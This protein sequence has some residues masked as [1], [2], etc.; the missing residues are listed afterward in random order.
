AMGVQTIIVEEAGTDEQVG[1]RAEDRDGSSVAKDLRLA[2]AQVDA[3][4]EERLR[5]EQVV[6]LIDADIVAVVREKFVRKGD[7]REVLRDVRLD[8]Q[9]WIFPDEGLR[10]FHLRR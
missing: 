10:G 7:L 8:V 9:V 4:A 6:L 1:G 2:V 3:V 5:P